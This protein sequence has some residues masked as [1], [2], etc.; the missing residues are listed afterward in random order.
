MI[1]DTTPIT[2]S[3][4]GPLKGWH[5]WTFEFV[6]EDRLGLFVR[7]AVNQEHRRATAWMMVVEPG[8]PPIVLLDSDLP[9]P[10]S[11]L[12]IRGSGIW[13]NAECESPWEH[14]ALAAEAFALRTD[15]PLGEPAN[16]R[17]ERV[18]LGLDVEWETLADPQTHEHGVEQPCLVIG[19]VL[20]GSTRWAL[21]GRGWRDRSNRTSRGP[22]GRGWNGPTP[23]SGPETI[24]GSAGATVRGFSAAGTGDERRS[25][26]LSGTIGWRQEEAAVTGEER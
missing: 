6:A 22:Y 19:E 9:G 1:E 12:E 26:V 4:R 11:G 7:L 20:V 10:R 16:L 25:V 24:D 8:Q 14:W 17:G 21:D 5:S 23:V 15:E 13:I 18:P 2:D 3:P